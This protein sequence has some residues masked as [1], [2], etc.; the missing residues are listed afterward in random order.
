MSNTKNLSSYEQDRD[1]AAKKYMIEMSASRVEREVFKVAYDAG[2]ARAQTRISELEQENL[3]VTQTYN[4]FTVELNNVRGLIV[5]TLE[6]KIRGLEADKLNQQRSLAMVRPE[7]E[8]KIK[9]VCDMLDKERELS[10]NLQSKL[11][12]CEAEIEVWKKEEARQALIIKKSVPRE[13]VKPMVEALE[14]IK[15]NYHTLNMNRIG[16][17]PGAIEEALQAFREK[18]K[19]VV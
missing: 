13:D 15:N 6:A 1:E 2:H 19:G 10:A 5:P 14:I 9:Q 17:V 8:R 18:H 3:E 7:A 4:T 12:A 16:G 11:D